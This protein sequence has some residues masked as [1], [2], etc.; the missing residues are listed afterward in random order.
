MPADGCPTMVVNAAPAVA[1]AGLGPLRATQD[2]RSDHDALVAAGVETD[3]ALTPGGAPTIVCVTR[4]RR[5]TLGLIA[6]AARLARS[7][8]R[9]FVDGQKTDGIDAHFRQ[10][11]ALLAGTDSL[12]RAHGRLIWAD[13]P[14]V[15]PDELLG[16][17]EALSPRRT[18]QGDFVAEGVFSADGPD[19][20]SQLLAGHLGG[21][22]GHVADLGAGWGYLAR[23]VLA[24]PA[25][26][27][28]DL[29]EV[30]Y[31]A[32]ELARRNVDDTRV[33]FHWADARNFDPGTVLDAVVANP[34]FHADR[35]PD[36]ALGRAFIAA[37]A[38]LIKPRGRF[39]MVANRHLPYEQAL[40]DHFAS[41][42]AVQVTSGYKV[43][44]ATKPRR[45]K[46]G[47]RRP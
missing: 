35:R 11:R 6:R 46:A 31:A 21:L 24:N 40:S 39:L 44:L 18:P 19:P 45:A 30:S 42:E 27:T 13:L 26:T 47:G 23:A 4:S 9:L 3:V 41:W 29:V 5:E 8:S 25:V 37:A 20:G 36:P 43:V 33:R 32:L 14:A 22:S 1:W 34:P 16:W 28:L 10:L 15:L 7:G 38:R 12:T 2:N 17:E